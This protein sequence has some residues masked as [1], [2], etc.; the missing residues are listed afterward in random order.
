MVFCG[1]S[2]AHRTVGLI[3]D[4]ESSVE[5]RCGACSDGHS[6]PVKSA[7]SPLSRPD[8]KCLLLHLPNRT[9]FLRP[10]R[11]LFPPGIAASC[12]RERTSRVGIGTGLF[13]CFGWHPELPGAF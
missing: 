3:Q 10:W 8:R 5:N 2:G 1:R 9:D 6:F 7:D 4:G 12:E 13:T 11:S